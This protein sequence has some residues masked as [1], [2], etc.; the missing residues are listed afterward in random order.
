M[1]VASLLVF[2][3]S[4]LV[5]GP[6][7]IAEA[8]G[9]SGYTYTLDADFD[10]G[11]SINVVHTIPNQLQLDETTNT[12]PFLWVAKSGHGT[13]VKIDTQTG[14]I[15]GEYRT[16]PQGMSTNPSRTTVDK[17]GNVWVGNRDQ[18]GQGSVVHV[19][20][21]ENGQCVDR[22]GNGVIDTST[23]TPLP[24]TNA[25][26]ADTGGGVSTAEDE[27]IIHF[28]RT[29]GAN[30]RHVSVDQNNN[31]WVGGAAFG[32]SPRAYDLI[33][34]SGVILRSISM[35]AITS[36]CYGGL[37]DPNGILWGAALANHLIR[38][39]PSLPNGA[40]GLI[41]VIPLGRTSYGMGID[42][43]GNIWASNWTWNT[44]QKLSPAGAILGTFPLGGSG[45]RGVAVTGDDD[46]WV[47]LSFSNRVA[48]LKN[49]GTLVATIPVGAQPT[50]VA[51]DAQ[52]K[53]WVTN[54]SSDNIMR[55]DPATNSVDLTIH[56]GPGS[57]PYNYSDMTGAIL[58]GAPET[59][60]W[61]V[62]HD[63]GAA[64]TEWG[65]VDWTA[66]V[67]GDGAL[68]V[69]AA[70]S[71]N[72]TTFGPSQAVTAGVDLTVADGRYLRVSVQ[73]TRDSGGQS[74][75]LYDLT[76]APA[77]QPP[78]VTLVSVDQ[79]DEGETISLTAIASDPDGDPLTYSWSLVSGG[80]V[81]AASGG[82]ATY[83]SD[84]GP[85]TAVIAV[86][87]ADG[88]GGEATDQVTVTV[89]NVAPTVDAGPDQSQYWGLSLSFNGSATDPSQADTAA[90]LNPTWDFGD[91]SPTASGLSTSHTYADP[92]SYMATLTAT[93]KDGGVGSDQAQV[94]IDK[95]ETG[96]TYTGSST[97]I[98]GF[99]ATL[100]AQLS[101]AVNT[102]T[103][104][105][106]GQTVT[107]TVDGQSITA[108]TDT[109]GVA[110][111]MA[112]ALLMPG[113]YT[114]VV[115]FAEGS[116]YLASSATGTLTVGNS[117]GKITAGTL[118]SPAGG[119]GGF[120]VHSDAEGLKG[121]VQYQNGAVKFHASTITAVGISVDRTKAWFTGTG[122]SG[123]SFV[124]YVEDN[125]EPGRND[126]FQLWIDGT[127]YN[128]DG[129]LLGGNIQIH[130]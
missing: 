60:N 93:D 76:V 20:L 6:G 90:G 29:N 54:L 39:D 98:F 123:E 78:E 105:L 65:T 126:K 41:Q 46:V 19:G 7:S 43:Q 24:W 95:R 71:E 83:F 37:V 59:G 66:D 32:G 47:A 128:G 103:A 124:A 110:T 31:V 63:S 96:L 25:G 102:A 89:H 58:I 11:T 14:Q 30:I 1:A 67:F 100:S 75:I 107:F 44:V 94:A 4:F 26:G 15:L 109:S 28:V 114:V 2:V 55:I 22:N 120:N 117:T 23:G 106:A 92:G 45:G 88:K 80:G 101:D 79:M 13:V 56:L 17:D 70:S 122:K 116:H 84:D 113:T 34:S 111:T 5:M 115:D 112:P 57:S 51:V 125:G 42:S 85:D 81:L 49:N 72:G 33:S 27:C 35:A 68:T 48:R 8:S 18:G 64:G 91:G 108:L 82:T 3:F 69:T 40:P 86:T 130:K 127:L 97:V 10:Q 121:Q 52:G 16:A 99:A 129:T 50:G 87:V 21:E 53:V 119:S 9:G 74:P 61:T 104:Q 12:F 118:R 73:F 36:C 62:I 77:N 38:I